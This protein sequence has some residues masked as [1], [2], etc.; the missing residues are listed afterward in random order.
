M[1]GLTSAL[2]SVSEKEQR[3]ALSFDG[4][5]DFVD[6]GVSNAIIAEDQDP[7]SFSC[8]VKTTNATGGYVFSCQ[9]SSG[10]SAFSV[11]VQANGKPRGIIWN[12]GSAHNFPAAT[13]SVDDGKWHHVAIVAKDES[14]KIYV[15]GELE[16]ETTG[17]M[18]L[19]TSTD[20]CAIGAHDA[21][22]GNFFNGSI[23]NLAIFTVELDAE[24]IASIY[25]A[26]RHHNLNTPTSN[27]SSTPSHYYFLGHG[28]FDDKIEGIVHDQASSGFQNTSNAM[29]NTD[30]SLN[31]V[32]GSG[33]PTAT[34][35]NGWHFGV[36]PTTNTLSG[37]RA[38][39]DS[40]TRVVTINH[41]LGGDNQE[42]QLYQSL[43]VEA[44][45][46]Y[47][48]QVEIKT[49]TAGQFGLHGNIEASFSGGDRHSG[50]GGFEMMSMIKRASANKT[51]IVRCQRAGS[52][53]G[54][55]IVTGEFKNFSAT[56]LKGKPGLVSG[57]TFVSDN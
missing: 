49:T 56:E 44:D 28:L 2:A 3:Y 51:A 4:S 36:Y 20:G 29:T 48:F 41:E 26:G 57:A 18:A 35:S 25:I 6:L 47:R 16:A 14:Q 17:G 5:N 38:S 15:D 23:T 27:Y 46:V 19:P 7:V 39:W 1:L 43:T 50:S 12:G 42:T 52:A 40:S 11:N 31:P 32:H 34:I 8:W 54:S 45:K 22:Q 10:S 55:G 21:G 30:W 9:K 24:A 53:S 37:T 13:T 33:E